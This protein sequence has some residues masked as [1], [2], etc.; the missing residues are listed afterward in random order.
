MPGLRASAPP[1]AM[2]H[3]SRSSTT[4]SFLRSSARL[5]W[6]WAMRRARAHAG[7]GT[8]LSGRPVADNRLHQRTARCTRRRLDLGLAGLARASCGRPVA[9]IR[10]HRCRARS[11]RGTRFSVS[12]AGVGRRA[13]DWSRT[14]ALIVV[15]LGEDL[16][17]HVGSE[18][19]VVC[20][21]HYTHL[22]LSF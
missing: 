19:W 10:S 17:L 18:R 11:T 2:L 20:G 7:L 6:A 8:V 13:E 9:E 21:I 3:G 16:D 5:D 15:G 22:L 1:T 12:R 14:P 4:P